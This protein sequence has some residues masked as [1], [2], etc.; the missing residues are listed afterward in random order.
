QERPLRVAEAHRRHEDGLR[1]LPRDGL[2]RRAEEPGRELL[3]DAA[4]ADADQV[5]DARVL[6][7]LV[8]DDAHREHPIAGDATLATALLERVEEHL[9]ALAQ[10]FAHLL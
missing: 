6:A 5:G 7:D 8:G 10:R 9:A 4:M 3:V 1:R 2:R